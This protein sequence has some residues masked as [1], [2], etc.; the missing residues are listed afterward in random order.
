MKMHIRDVNGIIG[1]GRP[2]KG[3]RPRQA[4]LEKMPPVHTALRAEGTCWA[5]QGVF[6]SP[7]TR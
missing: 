7:P 6:S 4:C 3:Q 1:N 5:V 2:G